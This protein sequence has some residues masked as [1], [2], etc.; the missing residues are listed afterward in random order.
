[1]EEYLVETISY[2]AARNN[3]TKTMDE[4][5]DNHEPVLITRQKGPSV[6]MMSLEDFNAYEET[7]YLH[8]VVPKMP[9][10]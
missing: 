7:A 10:D 1:M 6:V 4:V 9:E 8:L 5:H 3:L 2:T